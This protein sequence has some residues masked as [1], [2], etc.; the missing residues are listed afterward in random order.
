MAAGPTVKVSELEKLFSGRTFAS[1]IIILCL[2]FLQPLP[3]PGLSVA[4]GLVIAALGA[5]LILDRA[6]ALPDFLS[7]REIDGP[8]L[9][10]V[11]TGAQRI[12]RRLDPLFRRRLLGIVDPPF[13]RL[14]GVGCIVGGLAMAMP[15]PPVV[16]FSNGMPALGVLFLCLGWVE[17]DGLFVLVGHAIT[18][19]TWIYFAFWWEALKFVALGLWEKWT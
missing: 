9:R 8:K 16:L 10:R 3:V 13:G 6:E 11:L 7:R 17:R 18:V 1:A 5:R 12:F 14:T 15:L 2:P 19:G 4:C